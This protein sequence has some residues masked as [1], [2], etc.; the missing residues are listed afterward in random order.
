MKIAI[1]PASVRLGEEIARDL[2]LGI[3][4]VASKEFP[5]GETYVRVGEINKEDNILLVQSMA[6][7]QAKNLMLLIQLVSAIRDRTDGRIMAVIPY[8]AFSR[9][10]RAFLEGEAVSAKVVAR[11]VEANDVDQLLI[12]E[13][14]STKSL[15]WFKVPVISI[16]PIDDLASFVKS[17]G[18]RKI[19]VAPDRGRMDEAR[20]L[21]E[22]LG[23][24]YGWVEKQ[25][26]RHTGEVTSTIGSL[27]SGRETI[28]L[29]DD[30]I[31]TGGTIASAAALLKSHGIE[32][33][34]VA[35]VHGL[36][37][38]EGDK[39]IMQSGVSSIYAS[40]TIEGKY[41]AYSAANSISRA[42]EKY[43]HEL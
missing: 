11:A 28:L 33:V 12:V 4:E 30:L 7:P 17:S 24:E 34:E 21:A 27:P 19:V 37:A 25:R 16:D 29:F 43:A 31:S 8:L 3:V 5:D 10:D 2:D 26:D 42:V 39:K 13:P 1:G 22:M 14:H 15:S 36:F 20:K 38:L 41:T 23:T 6:P 18:D 32:K 9:Q 40:D 35:T